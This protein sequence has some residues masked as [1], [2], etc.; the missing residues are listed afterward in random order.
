MGV[1]GQ[2]QRPRALTDVLHLPFKAHKAV[3]FL[4][5]QEDL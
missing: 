2:Y 5:W 4:D 3:Q 1:G